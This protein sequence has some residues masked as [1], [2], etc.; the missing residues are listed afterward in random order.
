MTRAAGSATRA[1]PPA[2]SGPASDRSYD[3][4]QFHRLGVRLG[5]A[6][7]AGSSPGAGPLVAAGIDLEEGYAPG[8]GNIRL[9]YVRVGEGP[10]IVFLHGFPET[11]DLYRPYLLEFGRDH[12]AVAPNL[13][14][15][16]P[17]E[18]PEAVEAYAMP[19]LLGDLHGL[20]DYLGRDR[21]VLVANDWG[22][23]VAWVFASAWPDRVTR[24]VI[25]NGPHPALLLRDY[26][27]SRAQIAASQYER[28]PESEPAPYPAYIE[29]DPIKVPASL[30]AAADL[31]APDLA[32]A[33][34]EGV[35]RRPARTDLVVEVPTMVIWGTQD[36]YQLP[37]LLQG[38]DAYVR[39]LTLLRIEDAGHYPMR[40]HR[41]AVTRAIRQ[42]LE[43]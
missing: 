4:R 36:P 30:E 32:A 17:S 20:L 31:P 42:L 27:T 5:L 7:A 41:E 10:L 14:G 29:A 1:R 39:D 21:C 13:R 12:L 6:L 23:Y 16:H 37:G 8:D 38:L 43:R 3:R 2:A 22:A 25:I 11:W 40:S 26:R 35:A 34:F 28:Y 9:Y 19:H 24:L 15:V 18:R 33:F